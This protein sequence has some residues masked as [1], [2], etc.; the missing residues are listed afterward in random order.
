MKKCRAC[1][2]LKPETE[3]NRNDRH[4]N[5]RSQCRPCQLSSNARWRAQDY[6]SNPVKYLARG[7]AGF[8]SSP[9]TTIRHA[10]KNALNRR[11][12]ENPITVDQAIA[13]FQRQEG[14]CA[15]SGVQMTWAPGAGRPVATS[16]SMDRI[17]QSAGYTV[18]N[19]RFVCHAANCFR[20]SMT[21]EEMDRF[22]AVFAAHRASV[23]PETPTVTQ[24]NGLG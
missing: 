8:Q 23:G 24:N 12:T 16:V 15:L 10:V 3:F 5:L 13:L 21:D 20:G 2:E 14:K 22:L 7:V 6:A 9:R 11:P 17:N 19:V 1:G 4:G 18:D